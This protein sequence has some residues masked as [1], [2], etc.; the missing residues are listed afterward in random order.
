[1]LAAD[2][3]IARGSYV[4]AIHKDARASRVDVGLEERGIS[5][6]CGEDAGGR[7]QRYDAESVVDKFH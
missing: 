7:E 3:E 5:L 4:L 2:A 6:L 1:M